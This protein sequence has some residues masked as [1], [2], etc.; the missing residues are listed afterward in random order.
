[1]DENAK[2]PRILFLYL[3]KKIKLNKKLWKNPGSTGIA[4]CAYRLQ[5]KTQPELNSVVEI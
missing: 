1:M 3:I 2:T 4:S 5:N